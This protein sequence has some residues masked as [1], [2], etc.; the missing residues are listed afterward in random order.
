M[1]TGANFSEATFVK[2][3]NALK[4]FHFKQ[5]ACQNFINISIQACFQVLLCNK[6]HRLY[7]ILG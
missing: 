5:E 3:L 4:W 2:E 7:L 1:Q 6:C